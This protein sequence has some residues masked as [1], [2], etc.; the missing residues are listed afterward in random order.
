M[1]A[2]AH[3]LVPRRF[4]RRASGAAFEPR[5][6]SAWFGFFGVLGLAVFA[7]GLVEMQQRRKPRRVSPHGRLA[8]MD[9]R[10]ML[11]VLDE[12]VRIMDGNGAYQEL[13]A[14]DVL[15]DTGNLGPVLIAASLAR[16]LALQPDSRL[17]TVTTV[18]VHGDR[19]VS[20]LVKTHIWIGDMQL[21]VIAAIG[22]AESGNYRII[23]GQQ[24]LNQLFQSGYAIGA[25]RLEDLAN[26]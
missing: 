18:G 4:L 16:E 12:P 1:A 26:L 23:I 5:R 17:M 25:Y 2:H 22:G 21:E 15:L 11:S 14:G 24:V 3:S 9:S 6:G 19:A 7:V 20:E 8:P 13:G 10:K